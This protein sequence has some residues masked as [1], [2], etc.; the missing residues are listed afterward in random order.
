MRIAFL[1]KGGSGKST[2]AALFSLYADATNHR[3]G[4]LDVDVNSHTAALLESDPVTPPDLSS[5]VVANQIRHYLAGQNQRV[6]PDEMLSSTPPGIGSGHWTLDADNPVTARYGAAFGSRSHVFAVGSYT[7]ESVG[8]SCHHGTQSI[9]ENMLSHFVAQTDNDLVVI[10]SVAGNDAFG[11]TLYYQDALFFVVKPE[12]EGV[13]VFR[14]TAALAEQAGVGARLYAVGNQ[15]N[16]AKQAA[17]LQR[18][19]GKALIGQVAAHEAIS[20]TRLDGQPLSMALVTDAMRAVF[21]T[22]LARAQTQRRNPADYLTFYQE[23]HRRVA[24]EGWVAGAYRTGLEDQID[25]EYRP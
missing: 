7:A 16:T 24:A 12:R 6:T 4:L 18:E 3:V 15:V 20:D 13:D 5:P 9:A 11:G 17:F 21:D 19:L 22:I 25:P 2:L 10:D 8:V 14:R 23:L 1:G